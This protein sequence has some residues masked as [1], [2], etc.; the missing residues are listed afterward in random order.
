MRHPQDKFLRT[1]GVMAALTL[2]ILLAV[3]CL[4]DMP[5]SL[6]ETFEWNPDVAIPLSEESFGLN[7]ESGFDTLLLELDP[8]TGLPAWIE[9]LEIVLDRYMDFDLSGISE[10]L[11]HLNR[12]LFR[13]NIFN[14][15]P[16][17]VL[18]QAFF[19]DSGRDIVDSMFSEGAIPLPPGTIVNNEG[20][21]QPSHTIEDAIFD[22]ERIEPLQYVTEI[23]FRATILNP[24]VDT[25]LIPFYPSYLVDVEI[26]SMLDLTIEF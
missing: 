3:S 2:I 13:V 16:N 17:D 5:E 1:A 14:G 26:G 23:L 8:I 22:R 18:A 7:W 25:A 24:E 15:F 10:N 12:I 9:E 20:I 21:I 4:K 19:L 6:P 11:D